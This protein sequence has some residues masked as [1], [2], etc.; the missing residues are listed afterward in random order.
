MFSPSQDLN[1]AVRSDNENR[2]KSIMF[3][4]ERRLEEVILLRCNN[5]RV[6]YIETLRIF[7]CLEQ[8]P[9]VNRTARKTMLYFWLRGLQGLEHRGLNEARELA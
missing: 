6:F 2:S 3:Q 7:T 1:K 5:M 4:K 8:N 9:L